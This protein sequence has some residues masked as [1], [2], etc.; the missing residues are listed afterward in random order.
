MRLTQ[1]QRRTILAQVRRHDPQAQVRIFGS[2]AHDDARGGDIDLLIYSD[3]FD[4]AA[5]RE[6]RIDLQDALGEQHFDLVLHGC[7]PSAFA[8][9]VAREAVSL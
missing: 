9:S 7:R 5:L 4:R 6:L 8:R 1:Q 2:R 3:R